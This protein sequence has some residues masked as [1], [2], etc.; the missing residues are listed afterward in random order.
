MWNR[1]CY[2]KVLSIGY[3]TKMKARVWN[4]SS[5]KWKHLGQLLGVDASHQTG[6]GNVK[7]SGWRF[8]T[9][10]IF[11]WAG[12]GWINTAR[13]YFK[14]GYNFGI[15]PFLNSSAYSIIKPFKKLC[16]PFRHLPQAHTFSHAAAGLGQK[17]LDLFLVFKGSSNNLYLE[18]HRTER[19]PLP[20]NSVLWKQAQPAMQIDSFH[21]TNQDV[22]TVIKTKLN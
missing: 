7:H 22:L 12:S 16:F 3:A 5:S 21:N 2:V 13:N 17:N 1:H 15:P 19:E 18:P 14:W 20:K 10:T 9:S 11:I 4:W 8:V 6:T